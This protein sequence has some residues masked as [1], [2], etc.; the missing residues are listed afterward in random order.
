MG[1]RSRPA[2]GAQ[3]RGGVAQQVRALPCQGRGREFDP[4]R[5]RSPQKEGAGRPRRSAPH[6][7]LAQRKSARP[8]RG[9]PEGQH[10]Q[11]VPSPRRLT[12]RPPGYEPGSPSSN[13]GEGT[14]RSVAQRQSVG[15]TNRGAQV[16]VL[17][18]RPWW[19]NGEAT[20]PAVTRAAEG[21]VPS[22]H[23]T[24]G[25]RMAGWPHR[26]VKPDP[27][28]RRRFDTCSAHARSHGPGD[29]TPASGAGG[30]GSNPAGST[31]AR[32]SPEAGG[33]LQSRRSGFDSPPCLQWLAARGTCGCLLLRA[34]SGN[35]TRQLICGE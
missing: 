17:P 29:R 10:L 4:R 28:G 2:A 1:V 34:A 31:K 32:H 13:L 24:G 5:H 6:A 15:L 30:A 12:D 18:D 33:G 26:S 9:R 21:A 19:S 27:S 7:R 23:P 14:H 16:R 22:D 25:R 11:R 35:P 3:Y 8:T 20:S